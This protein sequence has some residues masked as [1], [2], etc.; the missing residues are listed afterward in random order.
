MNSSKTTWMPMSRIS[1]SNKIHRIHQLCSLEAN[2]K[3]Q[4]RPKLWSVGHLNLNFWGVRTPTTPAVVVRYSLNV[5]VHE[6]HCKQ[7]GRSETHEI[8]R[9]RQ[10]TNVDFNRSCCWSL[11]LIDRSTYDV[12]PRRSMAPASSPW[13]HSCLRGD[14]CHVTTWNT[15]C[16]SVYG[17]W[18]SA[19]R[20]VMKI[21]S[22]LKIKC[23]SIETD[24]YAAYNKTNRIIKR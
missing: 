10:F 12:T 3:S 20:A 8:Q 19:R 15:C 9:L 2:Y 7:A 4:D 1:K 11:T 5:S 16:T 18:A 14:A 22:G 23:N 6:R 21:A 24:K 13:Q 17:H